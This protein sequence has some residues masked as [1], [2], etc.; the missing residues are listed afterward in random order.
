MAPDAPLTYEE[1]QLSIFILG[2]WMIGCFLDLLLQGIL[3]GQFSEYLNSY[4]SDTI[5]TRLAVAG[6]VIITTLKS[7]HTFGSTWILFVLHFKDLD[8]AI[9]LNYTAWWLTGSGLMVASIGIY[10]QIFFCHRLWIISKKNKWI[11]STIL[12]VLLFAYVSCCVATFYISEGVSAGPHIATWFAAHLSSVFAGDFLITLSTAYFL[13][14]SRKEALPPTAGVINALLRLTFQ[15][16]APA[17]LCAMLNLVFSQIYKGQNKL[18]STAFN[19]GLAKLYAF[20]M[21]WTLNARS[22]LRRNFN[23]GN[24]SSAGSFGRRMTPLTSSGTGKTLLDVRRM[25]H[26]TVDHTKSDANDFKLVG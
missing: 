23:H 11:V 6:L 5:G 22:E 1:R 9:A 26:N 21:M 4:P 24:D 8:G 16:A 12:G 18:I 17:A 13:L 14:Q 15:T 20:S 10:V 19:Q 25:F 3:F 7:A 2:P